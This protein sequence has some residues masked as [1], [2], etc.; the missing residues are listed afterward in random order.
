MVKAVLST[1]LGLVA[2]IQHMS[3]ILILKAFHLT[4]HH[5]GN[6]LEVT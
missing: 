3:S 2:I 1:F 6:Q 5:R 4:G